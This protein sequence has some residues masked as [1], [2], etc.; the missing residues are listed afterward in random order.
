MTIQDQTRLPTSEEAWLIAAYE[1]LTANGVESVRIMPLA[2]KLGVSRTSFYWHFKDREAL[3][4]AMVRRWED[5]NTGN[6]VAQTEAYAA[7]IC[8][9]VFNLFDCWLD[10]DLFD[11]RLDLAIRNWA[12]NDAD[13]QQRL[14]QADARREAAMAA[15]LERFGYGTEN[16]LVRARTM[17]YTQIG[18]ISM[19]VREEED[20]RLALMPD[21]VEVFTGRSPSKADTDRFMARHL[22]GGNPAVLR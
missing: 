22:P 5:K 13:L 11:S 1:E 19:Q 7:T 21:Y 15:M 14:D 16:A 20:R 12:R 8:E 9:A 6:L 17:I 3:L 18:Y 10:A 2:K 4:E